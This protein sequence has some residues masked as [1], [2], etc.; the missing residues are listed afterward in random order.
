M[1][2][3][4]R[5]GSAPANA[6]PDARQA[7]GAD[8]GAPTV[9]NGS[10]SPES[11][12]SSGRVARELTSL[13]EVSAVSMLERGY[14]LVATATAHHWPAR[15]PG[16]GF[17]AGVAQDA[18]HHGTGLGG[19]I[20]SRVVEQ[21]AEDGLWPVILETD[22]EHLPAISRH[23]GFGFLPHCLDGGHVERWSRVSSA[24]KAAQSASAR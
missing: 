12:W 24:T 3:P 14:R 10:A 16:I 2:V 15:F 4:V 19:E 22:D 20:V 6:H 21:F 7:T 13:G 23:L 5:P 1:P 9:L 18:A 11:E 17:P 8:N